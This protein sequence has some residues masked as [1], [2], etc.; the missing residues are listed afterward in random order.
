MNIKEI[1]KIMNEYEQKIETHKDSW[2]I[3]SNFIIVNNMTLND[4]RSIRI[5]EGANEEPRIWLNKNHIR[6]EDIKELKI[7]KVRSYLEGDEE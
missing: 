6:L 1:R 5:V 3:M 4:I 2:I 7:L